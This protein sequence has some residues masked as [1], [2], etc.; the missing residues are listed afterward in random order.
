MPLS[1]TNELGGEVHPSPFL[2]PID[3]TG[4]VRLD[5]SELTTDEVDEFGYLK[6]GVFLT[7]TGRLVGTNA[8]LLSAPTF[9][10]SATPEEIAVVAFDVLI[11]GRQVT[12][13]TDATAPLTAGPTI[14][15]LKFGVIVVQVT[16]AGVISSKA[17]TAVQA[18]DTAAE[19]LLNK[20]LPDA[21]NAEIGYIEIEA[22]AGVWTA[23]TDDMTDASD[24]TTAA[25]TAAPVLHENENERRGYGAN[26]EDVKVAAGNTAALLDAATDINVTVATACGINR[27]ILEDSLG[28]ALTDDEL[29]NI[30]DSIVISST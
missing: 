28:R 13:A 14:T 1:I 9:S 12:V 15:S 30:S 5:V 23:A 18:Y 3:Q 25:F 29:F 6:P 19:A 11:D 20:P 17:V 8:V 27:D 2:G 7:R 22:D 24:L 4:T 26:V 16:V 10:I 21:G